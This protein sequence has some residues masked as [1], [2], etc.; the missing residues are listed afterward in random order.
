MNCSLRPL[1]IAA[2]SPV[3]IG[4]GQSIAD[5]RDNIWWD[6]V[7]NDNRNYEKSCL[8]ENR[9]D[10]TVRATFEL[11]PTHFDFNGDPM[12]GTKRVTLKPHVV[13]KLRTW[14]RGFDPDCS[15]RSY[16]VR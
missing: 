2:L 6:V 3:G 4:L 1:L 16:S 5:E 8:V 14:P 10:F 15:L 12:P 9:N 13:Y 7:T 11:I